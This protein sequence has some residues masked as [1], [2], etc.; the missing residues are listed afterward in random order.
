MSKYPWVLFL[1]EDLDDIEKVLTESNLDC[2]L[3]FVNNI[4]QLEKLYNPNYQ[5]L[6]TYGPDESKFKCNQVIASRMSNR[7][8]HFNEIPDIKEFSR[9]VNY[10]FIHNCS[11]DRVDVRPKFS[12]FTTCYESYDKIKRAYAS[13]K[14]QTFLDYEWIV[15]DDSPDTSHFEFLTSLFGDNNR[16]RLYKRS[17]N[18]GNIGNVKNEAVSMCRGKYVLELD[19]DDEI[20]PHVLTT[21]YNYFENN[22]ETGFIYMDFANIRESG[23]NFNYGD[24]I[25]K[26]YGSYYTQYYNG[27]WIYVYNT[28][29][30]NNITLSHLVCCPNHPR[31]WRRSVLLTSGN[32]SEFLPVCDDY[33]ILL[34]TAVSTKMAKISMLGYIQYINEK[35]NNFSF[36]RNSEINR[37]GPNFIQPIF[38]KKLNI[39]EKMKELGAYEDIA[40]MNNNSPVWKRSNYTHKYANSRVQPYKKQICVIGI[41]NLNGLIIDPENDYILLDTVNIKILWE[42]LND[43]EWTFFKCYTL[44]TRQELKNYFLTMYRCGDYEIID[45][46]HIDYNTSLSYRHLVINKNTNIN[47]T[48]LEI[49]VETGFTFKNVNCVSKIGVDPDPKCEGVLKM[50]SDDF[51]LTNEKIFNVVFIDGMHQ[52]EYVLR[53]FNNTLNYLKPGG[54]IMVDDILPINESEQLKIPQEH[55]YENGILKYLAPWTGDVW[56][57]VYHL[58]QFYNTN[59]M[60]GYYNNENYR[61]I[62]VFRIKRHFVIENFKDYDYR[63]H[64]EHYLTLFKEYTTGPL[65][66]VN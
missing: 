9:A 19:H 12:I 20:L 6:I 5:I 26:G 4:E 44:P 48:Y 54:L 40:F 7:W 15:I 36:I 3:F 49:G 50:T 64:F 66:L 16:V 29:N 2:T 41:E 35:E 57:V 59:F 46:Y 23:E 27:K 22:P 1:H 38:Y 25:C 8:I 31:I 39:N 30:I 58:L 10:C 28:P 11:M 53:D 34:R 32:Y 17:S 52:S 18:S 60:F 14:S 13:V 24:F 42:T 37:I 45:P 43:L 62:G 51:F 21:A 47:E 55:I 33:E 65:F 56:K 63:L 61:G